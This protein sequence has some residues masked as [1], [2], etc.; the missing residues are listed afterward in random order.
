MTQTT[1]LSVAYY[2]E[3]SFGDTMNQIGLNQMKIGGDGQAP[4]KWRWS[5]EWFSPKKGKVLHVKAATLQEAIDMATDLA[6]KTRLEA[7]DDTE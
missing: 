6:E 2:L 3:A 4:A 7:S 5:I 1:D